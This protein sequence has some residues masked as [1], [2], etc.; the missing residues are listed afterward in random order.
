MH[1]SCICTLSFLSICS[2]LWLCFLSL[3]LSLSDRLRMAPKL[4][5][6]PTRNPFR[7]GSSSSSDPPIPLLHVQFRDEKPHQ[8]FSENFSK[9]GIHLKCHVIL[10]DFS[11]TS[12]LD[13]IHTQGWE[14]LCE[15]SLRCPTMFIQEFYSNM[16][17]IDTSVP[18]IVDIQRYTYRSHSGSYIRDT[19]YPMGSASWIPGCLR[20]RTMSKD[21]LLSHFCETPSL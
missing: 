6:T 4:K 11:N 10:S 18:Q 12:L 9:R 7:S 21:E 5:S 20:L 8:D 13:V 3:S 17:S 2:G 14:S 1:F 19:T 15:I 16:H